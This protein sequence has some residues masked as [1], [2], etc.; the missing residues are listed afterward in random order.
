[1]TITFFFLYE[2]KKRYFLCK[3]PHLLLWIVFTCAAN[4]V[5]L[6]KIGTL[7]SIELVL[8]CSSEHTKKNTLFYEI[9]CEWKNNVVFI[10]IWWYACKKK[11]RDDAQDT[12]ISIV[13][14][15]HILKY[16]KRIF[17]V[18]LLHIEPSVH[19]TNKWT[20][21]KKSITNNTMDDNAKICWRR[22][23]MN[24]FSWKK[25]KHFFV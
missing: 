13:E 15:N 25:K 2:N 3:D 17:S 5:W 11:H 20:R 4:A 18:L 9:N 22:V 16:S 8:C 10:I 1:M 7:C 19:K 12:N 24:V 21:K 23:S 6:L 14:W